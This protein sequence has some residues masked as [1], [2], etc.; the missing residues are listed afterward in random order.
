M[1]AKDTKVKDVTEDGW[2]KVWITSP[3]EVLPSLQNIPMPEKTKP[4]K[5]SKLRQDSKPKDTLMLLL[6]TQLP[7]MKLLLRNQWGMSQKLIF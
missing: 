2:V 4:V 7:S 6:I 3:R 5:E 1:P